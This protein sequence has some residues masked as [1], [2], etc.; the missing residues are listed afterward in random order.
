MHP[1]ILQSSQPQKYIDRQKKTSMSWDKKNID[2]FYIKK[3]RDDLFND[4]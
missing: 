1:D 3:T 4:N 2:V